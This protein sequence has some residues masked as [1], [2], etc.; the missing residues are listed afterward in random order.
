[1]NDDTFDNISL[2]KCT[3]NRDS[4][5]GEVEA[6]TLVISLE[7]ERKYKNRKTCVCPE[8]IRHLVSDIRKA[9]EAGKTNEET[10]NPLYLTVP[11]PDVNSQ[12]D[13]DYPRTLLR[14]DLD[15][16][17]CNNRILYQNCL[18]LGNVFLHED[19]S[20]QFIKNIKKKCEEN[21]SKISVEEL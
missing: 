20:E 7:H 12:S 3:S 9:Q 4:I 18:F 16:I 10:G 14:N 8:D 17:Y 6:G 19:C 15:C 1:M 2:E 13:A 11:S 5:Y 21:S